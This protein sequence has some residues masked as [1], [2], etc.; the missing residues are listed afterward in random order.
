MDN[1]TTVICD[2]CR[3]QGKDK[4]ISVI[5]VQYFITHNTLFMEP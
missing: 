3:L 1:C 5:S 4:L 2:E